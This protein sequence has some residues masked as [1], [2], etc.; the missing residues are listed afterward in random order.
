VSH[1]RARGLPRDQCDQM[2]RRGRSGHRW[3]PRRGPAVHQF[4]CGGR[5]RPSC[6]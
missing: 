2:R 4:R 6:C 5:V 3:R 1:P